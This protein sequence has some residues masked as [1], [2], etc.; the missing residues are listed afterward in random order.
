MSDD[1]EKGLQKSIFSQSTEK[2][3]IDKLL[4]RDDVDK[5]RELIKKDDW[6][7]KDV[8]EILYLLSGNEQKLLNHTDYSRYFSLKFYVWVREFAK[9]L[10]EFYDARDYYEIKDKPTNKTGKKDKS[11][12]EDK[13]SFKLTDRAKLMNKNIIKELEHTTKFLIDL[14]LRIDRTS[15]SLGA[16]AFQEALT[17][18]YEVV[19]PQQTVLGGGGVQQQRSGILGFGKKT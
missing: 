13:P 14:L 2:S 5:M 17:N 7:R 19:Y 12:G 11:K 16:K 18:R 15:M 8:S 3:F 9:T 6:T 1:F 4:A 10:E